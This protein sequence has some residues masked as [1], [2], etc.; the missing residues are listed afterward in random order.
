MKAARALAALVLVSCGS[1]CDQDP[2]PR[3]VGPVSVS[4]SATAATVEWT[5][6]EPATTGVDYGP[7]PDYG[8]NFFTNTLT[9]THSASLA[10]LTPGRIHHYR[11]RSS[12]ECGNVVVSPDDWFTTPTDDPISPP[13]LVDEPDGEGSGSYEAVLE[14]STVSTPS[15]SVPQYEAEIDDNQFFASVDQGSGWITDTSWTVTV[16]PGAQYYWHVRAR[17]SADTSVMSTWSSYDVFSVTAFGAPP[18][19]ELVDEPNFYSGGMSALVTLA[20]LAVTDPEGHPV[21][22]QAQAHYTSDFT[23]PYFES[24]WIP[25]LSWDVTVPPGGMW[26][27]RV[28]ARDSVDIDQVSPW[29]SVDTFYDTTMPGSCPFLFVSTPSGFRYLTDIQG[30][31]IGLPSHVL[32][33]RNIRHYRPEH[34]VLS[35]LEPDG[36]GNLKIKIRETQTE[37]TY[38]DEATLLVVDHPEGHEV[39]SSTSESTYSYGYSDPF[40]VITTRDPIP[41]T[42]ATDPSG[43]SVLDSLLSADGRIV[44][45]HEHYTLDFGPFDDTHA[46]LVITGW[47][48]YDRHRYPSKTLVQPYVEVLDASGRWVKA[49][50]FGNPAGD[51]KTM[52]VDI[53]DILISSDHRLRIHMGRVHAIRW[54]VDAISL[55]V[56]E[57]AP[58]SVT[59]IKPLQ[60]FLYLSGRAPHYRANLDHPNIARDENLPLN[61]KALSYGRFTRYGPV[62]EL[63]TSPDDM[64]AI[65]R[66]GD[67]I[68]VTFPAPDPPP[69]GTHRTYILR[70]TLYYKHLSLSS[71]VEP[72]PFIGMQTYPTPGYPDDAKHTAY[73]E[74]Y[75]VRVLTR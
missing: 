68:L 13:T 39:L 30:P 8:L 41:P 59:A 43:N 11:V 21:Q 55:D 34:V 63:L 26:Y 69:P 47:S 1:P 42:S 31:A 14:W 18:A 71:T 60:A 25:D 73:L 28:Q 12:D 74:K 49:R 22:Y 36:K 65:M 46:K 56:S 51:T 24:G 57:P 33:T 2:P 58:V 19:P 67:E 50:S 45:T 6:D 70:S 7:T 75:N 20:W 52:A 64:Y 15:G 72:L 40:E 37:I 17:D 62:L 44:G 38:L 5:T 3:I 61:V 54:L 32:T 9:T 48:I 16:A 29:S 35:G 53:S 4:P 23:T 27:W 10:G 66:H